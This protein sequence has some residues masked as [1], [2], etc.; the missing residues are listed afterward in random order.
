MMASIH[1]LPR[2]DVMGNTGTRFTSS[3]A[4]SNPCH[5][6]WGHASLAWGGGYQLMGGIC[7]LDAEMCLQ[8]RP[9]V[10]SISF[11]LPAL[12]AV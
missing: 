6:P 1:R 7:M 10:P 2:Q 9:S 12:D 3:P 4:L 11:S 5:G 8:F